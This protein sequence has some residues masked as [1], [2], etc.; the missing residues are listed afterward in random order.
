V[1]DY[2]GD[3]SQAYLSDGMTDAL[4]AALGNISA[5][6][7]PGRST[8]MRYKGGQKSIQEMA[9]ELN[10]DAIV[11]GS[12]QRAGNRIL[13]TVKLI[14]A[15][16]DR[17]LWSDKFERDLS[18][19]FKVQSEV[20]RAIA[21][22]IQVRLTPEDQARLGRARAAKPEAMEAYL[23]GIQQWWQWSD[24][25]I[26]NARSY[27]QKAIQIEPDY[28]PAH[29]GLAIVYITGSGWMQFW[30]PAGV[31]IGK[32][33]AQKAMQLDPT[34]A[35]G[36]VA[37]GWA[38]MN[39]DWDWAGAEKDL[40]K[41]VELNPRSP[42]AL[43]A[44]AGFLLIRGRFDEAI[45]ALNKA[46]EVD[47][48]S[49]GLYSDL[50]WIYWGSDRID[51]AIPHFRKALELDR[52]FHNARMLLAFSYQLTGK[53]AEAAAEFQTLAQLAPDWP[54]VRGTL[55]Y[56]YA[57]TGRPAE[58]GKALAELNQLARKR[59]V[60]PWARAIIHIG[61]GQKSRALD[62][63]EKGCAEHDGWMWTLNV[64]PWYISLRDEPRFQALVKKVELGK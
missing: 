49:P 29:A 50:G 25:G 43:D 60:P 23:Q 40:R 36:Y 62:W 20:A 45:T 63:L 44:Y 37:M 5:L 8:V 22:G 57:V 28:A 24:Q 39:F 51:Q 14:E 16:T 19:F 31:P 46:L 58:A 54:W 4:C 53:S 38:R 59:Y 35:E 61:L 17:T 26:T 52:N 11:E 21:A 33:F 42:L 10:V 9:R 6:R 56:F 7:V 3:T 34:L 47:P 27:F 41:A 64:D 2:S 30:S 12:M 15:A 48:L 1:D 32:E 13:V 55:G 18:D